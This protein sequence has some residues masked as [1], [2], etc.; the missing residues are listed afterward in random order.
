MIDG[1]PQTMDA[2]K[3]E[4]R[5]SA[6]EEDGTLYEETFTVGVSG[7]GTT[8]Y[9]VALFLDPADGKYK[10][11]EVKP[12]SYL[13]HYEGYDIED[14]VDVLF[15]VLGRLHL[16]TTTDSW[17]ENEAGVDDPRPAPIRWA[18]LARNIKALRD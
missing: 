15:R 12:P 9:E 5:E 6:D 2:L 17:G 3:Q 8:E 11:G 7:G 4:I 14:A 16:A 18:G 13:S 10:V 1:D